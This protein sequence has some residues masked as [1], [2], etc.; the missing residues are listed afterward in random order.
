MQVAST[1]A[2][3]RSNTSTE[4]ISSRK[5]RAAQDSLSADERAQKSS[6]QQGSVPMSK[7]SPA[8]RALFSK[9]ELIDIGNTR[10]R[11]SSAHYSNTIYFVE[12]VEESFSYLFPTEDRV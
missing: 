10:Y 7:W 2:V 5:Q 4:E 6:L 9:A 11:D 12:Q 8:Q 1:V 3:S